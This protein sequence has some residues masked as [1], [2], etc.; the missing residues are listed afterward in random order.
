MEKK[1]AVAEKVT[2]RDF[3]KWGGMA[4]VGSATAIGAG[5]LTGCTDGNAVPVTEISELYTCPIDGKRFATHEAL[6]GHF[7]TNHPDALVP[8]MMTLNVNGENRKVQIEPQWTLQETL[9][10]VLGLTGAKTMCDRG[11]CGSCTVLVDGEPVLSCMTMAIECEDSSIE[12]V[13]GIAADEK[14]KPLFDGFAQNDGSQCGYCSPGQIVM[15]KYVI[16]KYGD[17]TDE[18]ILAEMAGNLCR[19]GTYPRHP[20]AIHY[21]VDA[22]KG[23]AS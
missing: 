8:E 6:Q 16:E 14:W 10:M 1:G 3:L 22:M 17:P 15:A 9:Q 7:K 5:D 12:T 23:D 13:E 4:A 21:A 11:A 18:Q 20:L 19:C 2:R